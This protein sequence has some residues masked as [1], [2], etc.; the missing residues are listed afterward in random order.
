MGE[1]L[2]EGYNMRT[3]T[4]TLNGITV[5]RANARR[6]EIVTPS[7]V[8]PVTAA[9]VKAH[10]RITDSSSDTYIES[11]L[12]VAVD[13][14]ERYISRSLMERTVKQWLDFL[15]GWDT[16]LDWQDGTFDGPVMFWT[17]TV[18]TLELIGVPMKTITRI[19]SIDDSDVE[20][21]MD[22][23]LYIA[24]TADQNQPSRIILRRGAV[25]PANLRVAKSVYI[26]GTVGYGTVATAVPP[27]IRH[28]ILLIAAAL[29]SNRGDSI[30]GASDVLSLGNIRATLDPYRV[31]RISL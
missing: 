19:V 8:V 2:F 16:D 7:T 28:A 30:D 20:T 17:D 1:V 15:P 23:T 11:L 3:L 12:A 26:L 10:L 4:R 6:M 29:W 31:L 13:I 5:L 21:I 18:R 24:D 25:W 14:V 9:E 22:P 27:S